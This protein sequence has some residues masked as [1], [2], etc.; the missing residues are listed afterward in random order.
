VASQTN[1]ASNVAEDPKILALQTFERW[2]NYLLVTTVAAT[3]WVATKNID[4]DQPWQD[5]ALWCFGTSIVFGIL[6]L[7]LIPIIA[8]SMSPNHV[9]IYQVPAKFRLVRKTLWTA[10]L[11]QT[12]R[13]QHM[14]FI[15]GIALYCFGASQ[16]GLWM[17][18]VVATIAV[19]YGW[20]SRPRKKERKKI[21][22]PRATHTL[23]AP[24]R[25][26]Q[27]KK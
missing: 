1:A 10:Y 21:F 25:W 22:P 20:A 23:E 2:S 13:P 24:E 12:C 19:A 14:L 7:A 6:T 26:S 9:S 17:P 11:T 15:A 16:G 18:V 5:A 4:V 3:G 27:A 8:Q